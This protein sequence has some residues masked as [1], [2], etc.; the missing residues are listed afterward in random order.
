MP[1]LVGPPR[2]GLVRTKRLVG[3]VERTGT[4]QHENLPLMIILT[5]CPE[6]GIGAKFGTQ[7]R[8]NTASMPPVTRIP[9]QVRPSA[10]TESRKRGH[11]RLVRQIYL[12]NGP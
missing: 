5:V 3:R 9:Y 11:Q 2:G 6:T 4:R 12:I 7:R 10:L 8:Y 1:G